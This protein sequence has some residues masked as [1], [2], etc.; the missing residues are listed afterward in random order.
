MESVDEVP[1]NEIIEE[2]TTKIEVAAPK[3]GKGRQ[4]KQDS[5]DGAKKERHVNPKI[6][7]WS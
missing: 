7:R 3:R 6:W 5:S 2:P 1:V 4:T